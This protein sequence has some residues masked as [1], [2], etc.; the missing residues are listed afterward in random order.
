MQSQTGSVI[1]CRS[2]DGAVIAFSGFKYRKYD[3]GIGFHHEQ[4]SRLK[5]KAFTDFTGKQHLSYTLQ[6]LD[7]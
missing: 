5:A 6:R 2:K 3:L 4:H 7:K 1:L